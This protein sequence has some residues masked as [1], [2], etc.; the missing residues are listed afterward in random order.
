MQDSTVF[1]TIGAIRPYFIASQNQC[2]KWHVVHDILIFPAVFICGYVAM[3]F[4][5]SLKHQS[6][7][8]MS[9]LPIVNIESNAYC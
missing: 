2:T 7:R 9:Y 6:S 5:M 1:A 8:N 3:C 4:E